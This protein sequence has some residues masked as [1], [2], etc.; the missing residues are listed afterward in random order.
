MK[1]IR[2]SAKRKTAVTSA[3]HDTVRNDAVLNKQRG[4][5]LVLALIMLMLLGILGAFALSTTTTELRITGN[6]RNRQAS[7]FAADAGLEFGAKD[8]TIRSTVT[9]ALSVT[10]DLNPAVNA[11]IRVDYV[12]FGPPP[13]GA[14]FDSVITKLTGST[15]AASTAYMMHYVRISSVGTGPNNAETA[16][17]SMVGWVQPM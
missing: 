1:K 7:F 15:S 17:E 14:G 6:Y 8:S 3:V 4:V 2:Q 13:P 10:R 16:A 12:R 9:S 5:A 11:Q